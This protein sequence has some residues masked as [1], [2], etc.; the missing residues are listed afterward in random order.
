MAT[1]HHLRKGSLKLMVAMATGHH[2]GKSSLKLMI[3][4]F[5]PQKCILYNMWSPLNFNLVGMYAMG[6]NIE[7]MF[8]FLIP[9]VAMATRQISL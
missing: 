6:Q 9:K 1:G 3:L 4:V 8:K 5:L 2:L 7:N